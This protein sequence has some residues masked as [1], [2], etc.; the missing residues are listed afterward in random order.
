MK[1]KTFEHSLFDKYD[2]PAREA[3]IKLFNKMGYDVRHNEVEI[4]QDLIASKDGKE[5]YIECEVKG[6]WGDRPFPFL[7]IR[8]LERKRKYFGTKTLY[9]VWN[10]TFTRAV[11]FWASAIEHLPTKV[12]AHSW[13]P[14]GEGFVII[15][16]ELTR[17][18]VA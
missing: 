2:R 3:S 6:G 18:V 12:V 11:M 8:I 5:F 16:L 10:T 7:D 13:A 17:E 4:M 15:P 14:E 1:H 9:L